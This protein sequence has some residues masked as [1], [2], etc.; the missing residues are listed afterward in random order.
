MKEPEYSLDAIVPVSV[1]VPCYNCAETLSRAVSSVAA[2][3]RKPA[4]LIL[5]NDASSER[6]QEVINGL[7]SQYGTNWVRVIT[8]R[9]NGGPATARNR[10]WDVAQQPYL[11][12]LD[13]DDS[14]H[15]CKIELQLGFMMA[16]PEIDLCGHGFKEV[17]VQ[18]ANVPEVAL[19]RY[20][21][22]Y[23]WRFLLLNPLATRTVM[24]KRNGG[25]RFK[26]GKRYAEDY[27][28]WLQ[29]SRDGCRVALIDAELAYTYKPPYGVAGLSASLWKGEQ[30]ELE[31]FRLLVA[32][33]RLGNSTAMLLSVYSL[34]KFIRRLVVA[35]WKRSCY[36][37]RAIR[38]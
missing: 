21:E 22:I 32:E 4:E 18:P 13:A 28:L 8:L 26:P 16:H 11:A 3:T 36:R 20:S 25:Y 30:G 14:W 35:V 17:D 10:G 5:V 12:F 33:G 9:E 23:R 37:N 31:A 24:L 1:V 2:Q 34:M 15:P 7:V 19:N 27:L 29:M 38:R 6:T